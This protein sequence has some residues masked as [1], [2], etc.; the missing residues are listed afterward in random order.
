MRRDNQK[1]SHY[2]L[3]CPFASVFN[4]DD[5]K[6]FG[7]GGWWLVAGGAH[8]LRERIHQ[9]ATTGTDMTSGNIRL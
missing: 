5:H 8:C 9:T 4:T 6:Y 3:P 2:L 1:Q 7:V